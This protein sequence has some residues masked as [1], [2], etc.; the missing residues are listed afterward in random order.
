MRTAASK[1]LL[2]LTVL[3]ASVSPVAAQYTTPIAQ[4]ARSGAMG[5]S[6]FYD[7]TVSSVMLDYRRGYMLSAL[8]DK[9]LRLQVAAGR[10]GTVLAA[11]SHHG[12]I[13]WHEQQAGLGYGLRAASWLHV[14][15]MARWLSRGTDDAHYER[16]QWLT[17]SALAQV[18]LRNTTLTLLGGTR[19]WDERNPWRWH[20]QAAYRPFKQWLAIAEVEEEDRIRLRMGME[21]AYDGRWFL[22]AGM[23][24]RPVVMTFGA[25]IRL[26]HGSIDVAVEVHDALGV[27]PQTSLSLWF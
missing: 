5:G 10:T 4:G 3:A 21:Y 1:L 19:P 9:S 27:T 2:L 12:D 22:R 20:L 26:R 23:A 15:V 16:H 13:T 6:F 24:T 8:A 11:Y 25:G 14:A 17:P 7:P 18:S